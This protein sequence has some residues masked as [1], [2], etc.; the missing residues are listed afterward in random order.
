MKKDAGVSEMQNLGQIAMEPMEDSEGPR[1]L[2]GLPTINSSILH[3]A[4]E[5][6]HSFVVS[7]HSPGR[8]RRLW[9]PLRTAEFRYRFNQMLRVVIHYCTVLDEKYQYFNL[10]KPGIIL[11]ILQINR[12][13]SRL[14]ATIESRCMRQ[15]STLTVKQSTRA[16]PQ[17]KADRNASAGYYNMSFP[18]YT[19]DATFCSKPC[20]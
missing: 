13:V 6:D 2:H 8:G 16:G 7:I 10:V 15:A 11:P 3:S 5:S 1:K 9:L 18:R 12:I 17:A 19:P 4:C 14:W 20:V